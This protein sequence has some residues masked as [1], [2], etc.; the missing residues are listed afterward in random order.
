MA[1]IGHVIVGLA[2]GRRFPLGGTL[3]VRARM[4]AAAALAA[5]P[6]VD[7]VGFML[8]VPYGAPFG[9][10]G[11]AHSLVAA[12]VVGLGCALLGRLWKLSFWR[13]ACL[14]TALLVS[15]DLLDTL[16]DGGRG[17]ALL[18]PFS[19]RRF[20]APWRLL[21]VA[22]IGLRVLGPSGLKVLAT[23]LLYFLPLLAWALWPARECRST[24]SLPLGRSSS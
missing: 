18:W 15:H 7:S 22:P 11:A 17:I 19:P 9:H 2:A 20:F 16:T 12:A 4:V 23:E 1:S 8:G 21:P 3:S 14:A 6:D 13:T 5:L 10:R 24:S